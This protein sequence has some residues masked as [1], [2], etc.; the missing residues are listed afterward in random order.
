[1]GSKRIGLARTQALIQ[2]LK[3]ELALGAGSGITSDK[4]GYSE[5]GTVVFTEEAVT[6]TTDTIAVTKNVNNPVSL[7]QP[8]GTYLKELIII[9]AGNIVTAGGGSDDFDISFG[10]TQ[11]GEEIMAL[12]AIL[13]G[14]NVTMTANVPLHLVQNGVPVGANAFAALGQPATSEALVL[15]ATTYSATAR[16]FHVNFKAPSGGSNLAT[17][18]TTIKVIGIFATV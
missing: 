14:A 8:A 4:L 9:P 12:K 1:M 2:N 6:A 17:A 15:S 16:K 3:R 13:D 18:N 5:S 11:H 10:T 7:Q